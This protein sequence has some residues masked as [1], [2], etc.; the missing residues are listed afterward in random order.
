[1]TIDRVSNML[2]SIKNASMSKKQAIEVIHTK[3]C[4]NVAKVLLDKQFLTDVKVFKPKDNPFK[5]MRLELSKDGKIFNLSEVKIISKPGRRIYR[6]SDDLGKSK[7]GFGIFVV[8]TNRGIV[9]GETARK[10]KLGG[11]LICEIY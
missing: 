9:D 7:G 11:E 3:K 10:K 6:K 8:S 2:S 4:E 1:M 5:M